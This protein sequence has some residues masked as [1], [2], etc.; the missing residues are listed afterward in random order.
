MVLHKNLKAI[1]HIS[2]LITAAEEGKFS[3]QTKLWNA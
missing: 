1:E 2:Q 3:N